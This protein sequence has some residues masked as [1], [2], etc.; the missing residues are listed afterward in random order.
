[1]RLLLDT[2]IALWTILDD[3][4]LSSTARRLIADPGNL[5]HVSTASIWEIA[6]KHALA[7]RR[8]NLMP[9]SGATAKLKF[10]AAE[11]RFLAVSAD[12]AAAIDDLALH[13]TDP[14][15]RLLVAQAQHEPLKLVTHD[16]RL[17]AYGDSVLL[18]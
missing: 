4:R 6:V 1:M 16:K 14:F 15:D 3:P 8:P 5:K 13:T 17:A 9:V 12:H 7:A 11:F 2:H 10:A 18:V